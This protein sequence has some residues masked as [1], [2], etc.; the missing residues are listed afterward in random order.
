MNRITNFSIKFDAHKTAQARCLRQKEKNQRTYHILMCVFSLFP[1]ALTS[2]FIF[3][4][5]TIRIQQFPK[6]GESLANEVEKRYTVGEQKPSKPTPIKHTEELAVWALCYARPSFVFNW[7]FKAENTKK[8][9]IEK[10]V[11]ARNRALTA[12]ILIRQQHSIGQMC[13]YFS[14]FFFINSV[15]H[16]CYGF[17]MRAIFC[18][19]K[20]FFWRNQKRRTRTRHR[21]VC[22]NVYTNRFGNTIEVYFKYTSNNKQNHFSNAVTKENRDQYVFFLACFCAPGRWSFFFAYVNTLRCVPHS[23]SMHF[24]RFCSPFWPHCAVRISQRANNRGS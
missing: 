15:K 23:I 20:H 5:T 6:D 14:C 16:F 21:S 1:F 11:H 10:S 2:A 19:H 3:I 4:F 13:M 24:F 12:F 9:R 22:V 7:I 17:S 18:T 8:K